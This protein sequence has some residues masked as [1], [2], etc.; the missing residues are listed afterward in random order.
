MKL[1]IQ[2]PCLNEEA[3]LP[4]T[5]ADLPRELP[6]FDKV[7]WLV[8]DDGSTDRTSLVAREHGV[9][10]VIRFPG[11]RGLVRAFEA[12]MRE[13]LAMG[14]DVVVN[15]DAD[16]QYFGG[17]VAQ[18]VRPILEDRADMVIGARPIDDIGDFSPLKKF[19]QKLG[20][21]VVRALAR[22]DVPD[23]TSG[24]RAY[25]RQ[26]AM[27][28][29][30]V[31]DF[32]YTLET[33]IQAS[34]KSLTIVHVP[35]RVNGKTRESRLFRGMGSYIRQ[36]IGAMFRV[37]VLYQPLQVFFTLTTVF[38]G[39]ALVLF[40][41]FLWLY[42]HTA[43][44]AN[45]GHVQSLVIAGV[46]ATIAVLFGALGVLSDLTAMNRR[47][48]EEVLLHTRRMRFGDTAAEER[49]RSGRE[50]DLSRRLIL[51]AQI[52]FSVV[53]LVVL[54]RRVPLG[55]SLRAIRSVQPLTIVLASLLALVGFIG[56]AARWATLLSHAGVS[57]RPLEAYRLTLLGVGYGLATPGRVGEFA[58]AA[59]VQGSRRGRAASVVWDRFA[60]LLL[61][62]GLSLPAF[63][64]GAGVARPVA[65]R[66]RRARGRHARGGVRRRPSTHR[67]GPRARGAAPVAGVRRLGR[68]RRAD[69]RESRVRDRDPRRPV[70]LRLQLR[71]G[72]AGPRRPG[73]PR[74]ARHGAVVP[75]DSAHRKPADRV[76]WPGPARAGERQPVRHVR[77][78]GGR[79]PRVL[80]VVLRHVHADPWAD[81]PG[82]AREIGA[83]AGATR[84]PEGGSR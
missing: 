62:E 32:T 18:L 71:R 70:L 66:V 16:N 72:L 45:A 83:I 5:L 8:I 31:T 27:R 4:A 49:M 81:R 51:L 48:I 82:V 52:A 60:D 84:I 61:L 56:R 11:R 35:I 17:D 26:A 54:A 6:G 9:D 69:V 78:A 57:I 44:G 75:T 67:R 14:A 24:F 37:Y 80:A 77:P 15:T 38:G 36:S 33:L 3:T 47:L 25:T 34:H 63:C 41:R 64:P 29:T 30:V 58:R 10:R 7:E 43:P 1:V 39:A 13:A 50:G 74:P 22:A 55:E 46:L 53:F 68:A 20:S 65:V 79:R 73:A 42:L 2:I 19:L 23:A 40:G 76:R 12:G 59:H 28:L 21:A